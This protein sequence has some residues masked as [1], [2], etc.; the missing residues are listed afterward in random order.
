M[1]S[2]CTEIASATRITENMVQEESKA[3]GQVIDKELAES[4]FDLDVPQDTKFSPD[5]K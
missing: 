3:A 4:L 1:F 2:T 5:R